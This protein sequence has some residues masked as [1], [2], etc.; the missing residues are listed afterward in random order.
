MVQL[1]V[2]DVRTLL[3]E[4]LYAGIELGDRD[5]DLIVR[6]GAAI[7]RASKPNG[8]RPSATAPPSPEPRRQP[9]APAVESPATTATHARPAG[10]GEP[11]D[12]VRTPE[13][14]GALKHRGGRKGGREDV[15]AAIT[16][17]HRTPKDVADF[18][19][20]SH[21]ATAQ[22]MKVMLQRGELVRISKGRY[23]LPDREATRP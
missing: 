17:G 19:R 13:Q 2:D 10:T 9:E 4:Y 5:L 1:T 7:E 14:R 21:G 20:R 8:T 23:A 22:K 18:A 6:I 12:G 3:E 16:A 11:P 15:V